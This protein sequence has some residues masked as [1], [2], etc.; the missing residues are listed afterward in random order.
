MPHAFL[1]SPIRAT[2]P[3]HLILLG[4]LIVIIFGGRSQQPSGL[5]PL[6]HWDGGS[7]PALGMDVC[8]RVSV[9]R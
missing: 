6:E 2:C 5:R 9:F 7:N 3:T 1:T 4:L 8:L